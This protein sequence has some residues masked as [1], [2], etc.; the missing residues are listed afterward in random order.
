MRCSS[1]DWDLESAAAKVI[2]R[3]IDIK[4][5]SGL[6]KASHNPRR[7]AQTDQARNKTIMQ[8][9]FKKYFLPTYPR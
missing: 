5:G 9:L 8:I 3:L 4:A 2:K 1:K 6:M 7:D